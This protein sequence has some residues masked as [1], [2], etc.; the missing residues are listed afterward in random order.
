MNAA[1]TRHRIL[2][3]AMELFWEKGYGSTSIAD[4][5]SRSQVHSGS[6]YHFFPGK[7][8]VLVGVLEMYRDGIGEMLLAPNWEGVD[9]PIDKIFALLAG[10]RTHLIVTDCTYGCPIGSLA[11]EIHEPDPVVRELMAANFT[12]W[13]T[14]IAGCF[15]AAADR[16]PPG[17]DAK[18]LG[19]FVLTVMEGAVMQAR[20]YRDIGYFDRNIAVLRDYVTT[21]LAAAKR[22]SF[23]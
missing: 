9:D 10:Y 21:L 20:T 16:L 19:E 6:L 5:L 13:S 1:D 15:D 4:I 7:Q 11:L 2:M 17:S 23:A 22:D 8:D 14:A 3:T 18:A 12:N